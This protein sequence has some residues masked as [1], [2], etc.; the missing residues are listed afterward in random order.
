MHTSPNDLYQVKGLLG[1]G[2]CL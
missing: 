1:K 2:L